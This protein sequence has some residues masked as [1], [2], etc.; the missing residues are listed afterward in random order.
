MAP[1]F[2]SRT[3]GP[4]RKA[5]RDR[6]GHRFLAA[7]I[8]ESKRHAKVRVVGAMDNG[9][10]KNGVTGHG[11]GGFLQ[12]TAITREA[13]ETRIIHRRPDKIGELVDPSRGEQRT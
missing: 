1:M 10:G 8:H 2:Q 12:V 11:V 7:K 3:S 6:I 9:Q 5:A 13:I 4:R